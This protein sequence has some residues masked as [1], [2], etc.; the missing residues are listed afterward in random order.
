MELILAVAIL[1]I[2]VGAALGLIKEQVKLSSAINTR[3]NYFNDARVAMEF[4]TQETATADERRIIPL[5]SGDYGIVSWDTYNDV[6]IK[7]L[8]S[9]T[10]DKSYRLFYNS[11]ERKLYRPNPDD[12]NEPDVVAE[13]IYNLNI[14][15]VPRESFKLRSTVPDIVV[16]NVYAIEVNAGIGNV[17]NSYTLKA[18]IR[19]Q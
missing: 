7:R 15:R 11:T 6:E 1:T 13:N 10:S 19:A 18:Y 3:Q 8:V 17:D 4:I 12:P 16:K 9:N 14:T 2:V 5:G